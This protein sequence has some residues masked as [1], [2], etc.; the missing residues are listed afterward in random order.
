MKITKTLFVFLLILLI[1]SCRKETYN[2]NQVFT[3]KYEQ[4]AY[5]NL[6][7]KKTEIRFTELKED[8]RC[9]PDKQCYVMGDVAVE[10]KLAGDK[11]ILGHHYDYPASIVYKNHVI[12]LLEVNYDKKKHFGKESHCVI[13]LRVD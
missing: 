8:S 5:L 7:G 1:A 10:I 4:K 6:D 11:F 12:Q 3:L 2:P 13:K 9:P